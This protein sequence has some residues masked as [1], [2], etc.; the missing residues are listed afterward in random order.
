MT[1]DKSGV[2]EIGENSGANALADENPVNAYHGLLFTSD[3]LSRP[4]DWWFGPLP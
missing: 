3:Y 1:H 2:W 4:A